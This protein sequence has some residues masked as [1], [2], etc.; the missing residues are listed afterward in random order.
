M[1]SGRRETGGVKVSGEKA[2]R[3][4]Q[5][6]LH[7]LPGVGDRTIEKIL[8]NFGS[9][10]Q[11]YQAGADALKPLIRGKGKEAVGDFTVKWDIE[12]KYEELKQKNILFLTRDDEHY[13]ARLKT[14]E[15]PPYAIYCLGNLPGDQTPSVAVIGA[16]ECS[17]YGISMARAFASRIAQAGVM[18]ISGM[19]RGI[20]GIG[21]QAAL[22]KGGKTYAVLGSGVDVCYPA[23]NKRLYQEILTFG[24]GI[25]STFPPGTKPIKQQFPE[26]NRIV[27]G[28]SD[29]LLVVEARLKSGTWITVDM[30]LEQG[31]NVYAVPGRLT[32]RLSDGC[33]YLIR[34]GAEI[35][36]T[37]ED[38]LAELAVLQNRKGMEAG[39]GRKGRIKAE[40][41]SNS[42]KNKRTDEMQVYDFL[43]MYPKS[44]D[45]IFEAM[46]KKGITIELS[47]LFEQLVYLCMEKK[48]K[49]VGS[50]YF[51]KVCGCDT[52]NYPDGY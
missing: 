21:Q 20:D 28:L 40:I 39:A 11:A 3:P 35:A 37:P 16:R 8:K 43:D 17:E 18:V 22:E 44:A 32:D 12:K 33:N 31:K 49:Q 36:L 48:A 10:K 30:A 41:R 47:D 27:A 6:W 45:E 29:L 51:A 19:A 13:P 34:Q 46:R 5:Y 14:I 25:L 9:A 50:G 24:G 26:R 23:S 1:L 4:Y 15:N 38:I 2:D 52:I 42:E 7:N